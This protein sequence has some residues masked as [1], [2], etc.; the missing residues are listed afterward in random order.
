MKNYFVFGYQD[1]QL[2]SMSP[3]GFSELTLAIEFLQTIEPSKAPFV[4]V[5]LTNI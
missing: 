1:G 2:V 3:D 5:R 4:C